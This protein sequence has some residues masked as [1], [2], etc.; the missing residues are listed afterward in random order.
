VALFKDEG[1]L[2]ETVYTAGKTHS[3]HLLSMIHDILEECRCRPADIGGIAVTQGPGTFTGLRIGLSTVKGLAVAI[4]VPVVGVS[5]LASLAFPFNVV[6][7]PVV[8][9]IDARRGEVYYA[10]YSGSDL[11][12]GVGAPVSV[13]MPEA[14]AAVLPENAILVGSG[15]V[16]Y[17]DV[18]A[19][20]CPRIRFADSTQHII[21]AA[22]V[23]MLALARFKTQNVDSIETLIPNYIRKSDAQ[24]QKKMETRFVSADVG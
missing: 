18:F 6:D 7:C 17:R 20:R 12:T 9:M 4:R 13:D 16:L 5:S 11:E 23:G 2:A 1:L 15:A 10:Q 19:S 22:S 21:R 3:R 8:S 14:V 24:I